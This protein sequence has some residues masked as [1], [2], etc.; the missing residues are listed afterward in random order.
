MATL[1]VRAR[2]AAEM[3]VLV[4]IVRVDRHAERGVAP[5]GVVADLQRNLELVEPLGHHRQA[6]QP[7]PVPRHEVDRVG[8]HPIGGHREIALVLA[9]L[10]VDDDDHLP[11]A[12]AAT[13][14]FH[15]REGRRTAWTV[16]KAKRASS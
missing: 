13:R 3:P 9:I 12:I 8:R 6:D 7:A 14:A 2:S 11:A 5:R 10:V 1:M 15:A 4:P 16:S